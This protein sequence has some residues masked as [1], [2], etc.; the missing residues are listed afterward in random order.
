MAIIFRNSHIFYKE[1]V[2]LVGHLI[3]LSNDVRI[4]SVQ[5]N[6]STLAEDSKLDKAILLNGIGQPFDNVV[7][8]LCQTNR[9]KQ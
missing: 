9:Y 6:N 7:N 8:L 4:V 5:K 2:S 1:A 3:L